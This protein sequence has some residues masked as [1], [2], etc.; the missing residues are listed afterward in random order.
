MIPALNSCQVTNVIGD[1]GLE[2]VAQTC[3][4]LQRLRIE[5]GDEDQGLGD[6][7]GRVTQVGLLTLAQGCPE[8]EYMAVYAS[9]IS[10]VALESLGNF[11][12]I[13]CDFWLVLLDRE[14]R[15]TELSLDNGLRALLRGCTKLRRFALYLRL[16]GLSDV[17]LGY[18]GEY[19]CNVRWILMG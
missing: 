7:Q 8:L 6:E 5:R 10:N 15:I 11:R 14:E 2:V 16:G 12:K 4:K 3:K 18:I 9:D 1:R 13:L 19:G 17:G